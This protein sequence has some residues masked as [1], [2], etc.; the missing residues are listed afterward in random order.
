MDAVGL[1]DLLGRERYG[2]ERVAIRRRI[3][4]HKRRRRVQVGPRMSLLFEDCATVWYQTQE[5]LW[6]E[7]ITD[8]DAIR[9]ELAV[10]GELLPAGSELVATLLIE[11]TEQAR[12][13]E[14]LQRLRGIDRHV[15]L[16]ARDERIAAVFE[17][18]RESATKLSAVQYIRFPLEARSRACVA[19]GAP[20]AV[21]VDHPAY[22][23]RAPVPEEVRASLAADL[24][25]ARAA[26]TALRQVRDG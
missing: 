22:S 19:E 8:L 21:V 14:E 6:V 2:A 15:F 1:E 4:E 23:Y 25:D 5:M 13:R 3:I 20:L 16:E 10:Y 7:H 18:G 9:E 11:M 12:I 17:G 24:R 26:R